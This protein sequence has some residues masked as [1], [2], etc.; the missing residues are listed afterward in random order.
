MWHRNN[1]SR[2][3]AHILNHKPTGEGG[4]V[5]STH[6]CYYAIILRISAK[7]YQSFQIHLKEI[8]IFQKYKHMDALNDKAQQTPTYPS[9]EQDGIDVAVLA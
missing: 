3:L 1:G 7:F 6:T 9:L 8:D 2:Q 4:D 5:I